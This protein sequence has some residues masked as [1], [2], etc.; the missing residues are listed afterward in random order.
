MG[1]EGVGYWVW[2]MVGNFGMLNRIVH[3]VLEC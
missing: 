2:E 1:G 3:F